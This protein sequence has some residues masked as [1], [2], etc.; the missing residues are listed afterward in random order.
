M[1][2]HHV[3]DP[4]KLGPCCYVE[5]RK[6]IHARRFWRRVLLGFLIALAIGSM[7]ALSMALNKYGSHLG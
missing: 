3:G 1:S 5:I 2:H 7:V 4:M 6:D